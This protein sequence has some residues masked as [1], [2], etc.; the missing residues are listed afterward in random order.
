MQ[1]SEDGN[2][3]TI[4]IVHYFIYLF[5]GTSGLYYS[6]EKTGKGEERERGNTQ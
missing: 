6:A 3:K 1:Y 4:L 2:L 5:F